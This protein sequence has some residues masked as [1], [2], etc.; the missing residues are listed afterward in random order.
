MPYDPWACYHQML[1]SRLYEEAVSRLWDAGL[2]SGEMHTGTGEEAINAGVVGQLQD[3][4]ALALDHR[5]TGPLLMRGIDPVLLLKE[6]L[7]QPDGLCRGQGGHMHLFSP[8][9]LSASSGIV[10]SSGP[11]AAGF[12][13]AAQQLRP[14][15]LAVAFFGEGAMNE[16]ML[17]ES[18]NLAVVWNLPVIFVCKDNGWSIATESGDVTGGNLIERVRSFGI[19]VYTIDG[20]DIEAVWDAAESAIVRTRA[21]A[22]PAFIHAT[23]VHIDGHFLGDP[24]M[25]LGKKPLREMT[26]LAGPMIRSLLRPQGT[27]LSERLT[28]VGSILRLGG[29]V[30]QQKATEDDPI[31][32]ARQVLTAD[33]GRLE[34]LEQAVVDELEAAVQSALVPAAV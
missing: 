7:G 21:G 25:R 10:G 5:G 29:R 32:R 16:G 31:L 17:M 18:L 8:D 9:L 4:D 33:P 1:R 20:R 3:G 28:R 19:A 34:A 30:A 24:L 26:P 11:A 12:G 14:N 13:L 2:I 22:G 15:N 23:C 27:N 6:L